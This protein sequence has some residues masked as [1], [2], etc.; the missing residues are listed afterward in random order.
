[1][2]NVVT[3]ATEARIHFQ[4]SHRGIWG[5]RS[6]TGYVFPLVLGFPLSSSFHPL[7][8]L[9]YS[10]VT[11]SIQFYKLTASLNERLLNCTDLQFS[12]MG[13]GVGRSTLT[14]TLVCLVPF[15]TDSDLCQVP[16]Y[17]ILLVFGSFYPCFFLVSIQCNVM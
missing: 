7:S 1:M 3:M 13:E 16:R 6:C 12:Y 9:I 8:A 10:T 5:A 11:N 14:S 2:C 17:N 15:H 4:A